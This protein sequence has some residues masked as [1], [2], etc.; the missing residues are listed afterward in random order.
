MNTRFGKWV[1][2]RSFA[3]LFWFLL[4]GTVVLMGW[5]SSQA[6]A[7]L[8]NLQIGPFIALILMTRLA[9]DPDRH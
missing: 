2:T 1:T 8:W 9:A 5:R 3:T 4:L 7:I 6:A